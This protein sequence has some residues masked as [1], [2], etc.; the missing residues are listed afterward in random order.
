MYIRIIIPN[1]QNANDYD[2]DHCD[3]ITLLLCGAVKY[4]HAS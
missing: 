2:E 1:H 4:A 3:G